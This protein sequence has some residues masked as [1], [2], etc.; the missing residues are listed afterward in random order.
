MSERTA[1]AAVLAAVLLLGLLFG[2][3]GAQIV[4]YTVQVIALSDLEAAL[5]VETDLR[6]SGF[7][8]YVVR[9]TTEQ[10][11]V[12]RVRVGAF[13]DRN[14]ALLYASGMPAVAG[15]MPVPAVAE[16]IPA[17]I[18]PLAPRILA[19]VPVAGLDIEVGVLPGGFAMRLQPSE[20][21]GQAEYLLFEGGAARRYRAWNLGID[22]QG[23]LV[24]VREMLLWPEN[25]ANDPDDVRDGFRNSLLA[26][27]AERLGVGVDVLAAAEYR[28]GEEEPPRLLVV[29]RGPTSML[30]GSELL[31]IG[32]PGE[33]GSEMGELGP[34]EFLRSAAWPEDQELPGIADTMTLAELV[35]LAGSG[36]PVE[37]TGWQAAADA[38]YIRLTI[39][40]PEA[41]GVQGKVAQ[42]ASWR[43]G[44]GRPL[45]SDGSYLIAWLDER[46]LVYGFVLR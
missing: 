14:A 3:A 24:R 9:S 4:P 1:K 34:V 18:M 6:R 23:E 7:H 19:D 46:L 35:E 5:N 30:E 27:V 20:P 31:G 36:Q 41:A 8:A 38:A 37:G 25:W 16:G 28:L 29:E 17:D 26:L 22:E 12:F 11:A 39:T 33:A 21:L 15:S 42:G 13:A 10:G 2:A 32:L 40:D 45:W 43:A 44:L